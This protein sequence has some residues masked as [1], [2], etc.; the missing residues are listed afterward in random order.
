MKEKVIILNFCEGG[1]NIIKSLLYGSLPTYLIFMGADNIISYNWDLS[2]RA[3]LNFIG[4]FYTSK[5]E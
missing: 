2:Q 4:I 3:S 1:N 5:D